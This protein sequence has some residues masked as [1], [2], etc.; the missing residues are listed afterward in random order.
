[1]SDPV[2][3]QTVDVAIVGAGPSGLHAARQLAI[4]GRSVV[5]LE[6]RDRVGGRLFSPGGFDLGPSWFWSNEPRINR[7]VVEFGLEAFDQHLDG[8]AMFQNADG[9]QRMRGNQVDAPSGRLR[10]GMQ[11]LAEAMAATLDAGVVRLNERVA[12]IA[13]S[14]DR[15]DVDVVSASGAGR[16]WS[17]AS[18]I[19]ALPP[20]TAV[21]SIDVDAALDADVRRM[22]EKT[23]VWM[24]QMTKVVARYER[25]FWRD[26]GLAGSAFSYVGP[27]REVHDMSG[28]DGEP[29]AIF[30]FAQPDPGAPTPSQ[31]DVIAQF[32]QLFGSR[33]AD[34]IE[35][36]IQDWRLEPST[37]PVGVE[38]LTVHQFFGHSLFQSPALGGR[39][40]W[41]ST[42]TST[43]APG[44]IEGALA[45]AERAVAAI[46]A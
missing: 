11:T 21:G 46:I 37:S 33:A 28:P 17:A 23:P 16:V 30:G 5:V 12:S 25:P 22:A 39:L 9:A 14:G 35:L 7:L 4:A 1:M 15:L 2:E 45:A 32:V 34:P 10:G 8:D 19:V 27:M 40:H 36:L 13:V 31:G 41:A 42:E 43:V 26:A 24:G 44:H 3:V 20:A 38:A 29:A 18:V 6:A